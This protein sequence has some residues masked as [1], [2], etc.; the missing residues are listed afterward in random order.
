[1]D[2]GSLLLRAI[3]ENPADD[4]A[5][6][7]YADWLDEHGQSERAEFIRVQIE[8][9]TTPEK[10]PAGTMMARHGPHVVQ[11]DGQTLG[12]V[13]MANAPMGLLASPVANP[14]WQQLKKRESVLLLSSVIWTT[15]EAITAV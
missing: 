14:K 15:C 5:R 9:Q 7:V 11:M 8:L 12:T 6:L 10:L 13:H 3:L 4:S 2:H 1:M